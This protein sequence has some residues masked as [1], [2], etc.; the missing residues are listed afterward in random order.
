[1]QRES[2]SERNPGIDAMMDGAVPN[3]GSKPVARPG[4]TRSSAR[5]RIITPHPPGLGPLL[6][7]WRAGGWVGGEMWWWGGWVARCVGQSWGAW[8]RQRR[9][10]LDGRR[11]AALPAI[12]GK[13][14]PV[15]QRSPRGMNACLGDHGA[16]VGVAE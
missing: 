10:R 2:R 15:T 16:A 3:A 7:E 5:A 4:I 6:M 8:G 14:G 13:G 12:G 9:R 1:M 11:R